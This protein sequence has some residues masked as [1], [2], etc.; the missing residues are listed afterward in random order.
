MVTAHTRAAHTWQVCMFEEMLDRAVVSHPP[1]LAST[2]AA[3]GGRPGPSRLLR[4][5]YRLHFRFVDLGLMLRSGKLVSKAEREAESV[6]A[7]VRRVCVRSSREKQ[8]E[9]ERAGKSAPELSSSV[10][11]LVK[12]K[13]LCLLW[14][15]VEG[16]TRTVTADFPAGF[17][18]P[19]TA[20][21]SH[22]LVFFMRVP[23]P[24]CDFRASSIPCELIPPSSQ[25]QHHR[26][27]RV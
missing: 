23:R 11:V 24:C 5:E 27:C 12:H 1:A 8:R 10:T 18:A 14:E 26:C 17:P 22:I 21:G 13:P 6:R 16:P 4:K 20:F 2:H 19:P 3:S 9:R 25:S 7:W 15:H